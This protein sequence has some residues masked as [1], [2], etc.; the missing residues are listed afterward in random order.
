MI[1]RMVQIVTVHESPNVAVAYA[2]AEEQLNSSHD[3]VTA[4]D[5]SFCIRRGDDAKQPGE[6]IVRKTAVGRSVSNLQDAL[7]T[8]KKTLESR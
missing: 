3:F 8:I 1:L 2:I 6:S 7:T 4:S 5:L